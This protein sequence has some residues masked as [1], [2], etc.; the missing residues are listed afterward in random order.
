[1]YTCVSTYMYIFIQ[2]E[3]LIDLFKRLKLAY[4]P[5]GFPAKSAK[6][7][8]KE[9]VKNQANTSTSVKEIPFYG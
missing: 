9:K 8:A 5:T 4:Q 3:V 1:M 7:G 2:G 6:K